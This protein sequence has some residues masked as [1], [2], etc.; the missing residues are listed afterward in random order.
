MTEGYVV[1]HHGRPVWVGNPDTCTRPT[2]RV[3]EDYGAARR[4]LTRIVRANESHGVT[5]NDGYAVAR[6]R[7]TIEDIS[8]DVTVRPRKEAW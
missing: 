6:V 4:E 7:I 1:T 8:A 3:R 2:I 5:K